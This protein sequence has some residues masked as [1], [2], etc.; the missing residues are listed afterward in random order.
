MKSMHA[1]AAIEPHLN[2]LLFIGLLKFDS[3]LWVD[4]NVT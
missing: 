4:R 1:D 3:G 2:A